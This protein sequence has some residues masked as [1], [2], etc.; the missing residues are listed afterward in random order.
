MLKDSGSVLVFFS[1]F[2][3]REVTLVGSWESCFSLL[4]LAWGRDWISWQTK[5]SLYSL[6]L[7]L[8]GANA[9]H[10]P[11]WSGP[12]LS[13]R[14]EPWNS[15]FWNP[16]VLWIVKS[17]L[18]GHS[19]EQNRGWQGLKGRLG[20]DRQL[21]DFV[22]QSDEPSQIEAPNAA[23]LC[24]WDGN[25]PMRGSSLCLTF[26]ESCSRRLRGGAGGNGEKKHYK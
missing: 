21:Q 22:K 13:R 12:D 8:T 17:W 2:G 11:A 25:G 6:Y 15:K 18:L 19:S 24:N 7:L 14:T 4:T 26:W 5:H 23:Q 9:G 20:C 16:K 3:S 10:I 1:L